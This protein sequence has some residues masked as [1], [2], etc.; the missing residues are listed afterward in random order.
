[1]RSWIDQRIGEEARRL[2]EFNGESCD[3]VVKNVLER[4][5]RDPG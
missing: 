2:Y 4:I 5:A 3:R 1:L